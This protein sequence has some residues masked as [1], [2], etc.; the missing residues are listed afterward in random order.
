MFG[1]AG[2]IVNVILKSVVFLTVLFHILSSKEDPAVRLVE[3]IPVNNRI[4]GIAVAS[5]T[6]GIR[7]VFVSCMKLAL[8]H[9]AFT[10]VTFRAL[11]VHFV[12]TSTLAGPAASCPTRHRHAFQPL[13]LGLNGIL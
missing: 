3:L 7:G 4:K 2:G 9:A 6:A 11:G 13:F 12:Y 5:L 1:V 8:F 10:W